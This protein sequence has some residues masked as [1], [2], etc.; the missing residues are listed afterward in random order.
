MLAGLAGAGK[1]ALLREFAAAGDHVVDLEALAGHSGSAFGGLGRPP[2]PAPAAFAA[3]LGAALAGADPAATTWIE[4]EGRFLGSLSVPA[5]LQRAIARAGVVQVVAPREARI[6]RLVAEY[7][8]LDPGALAA[9]ARRIR[10]R[11]GARADDAADRFRRADP[12]S[13]IDV[14]LPY[15]DDAYAHRWATLDR[16]RL[17]RTR[18]DRDS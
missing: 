12:A 6:A 16:P 4:D 13:A 7:G 11:C 10:P 1:T 15:F 17:G 8:H 3:A 2:Q 18:T 9:A 5:A 14:L